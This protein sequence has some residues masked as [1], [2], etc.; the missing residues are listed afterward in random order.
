MNFSVEKIALEN[1]LSSLQAFLEK[2]DNAEITSHIFF[3]VRDSKLILKATDHETGLEI[4]HNE[5]NITNDGIATCNGKKI[6]DIVRILKDGEVNIYF[7]NDEIHIKQNRSKYK[8]PSFNAE[9]FPNFPSLI[10]LPKVDINS[11]KLMNGFKKV[12]PTI[13]TNNPKF[14]LNGALLDIR[15]SV[16]NIV[17]TD[18]RR[19]A[20]FKIDNDSEKL[21]SLIIPKKAISEIQKLFNSDIEIFYDETNFI[22]KSQNYYFFT[23]V[24][25]GNFPDYE[26][27]IPRELKHNFSLPKMAIID[28]IKQVNIIAPEIKISFE[29]GKMIFESISNENMEAKTELEVDIAIGAPFSVAINSRYII[30]FLSNIDTET[31]GI[32][33]NEPNT[34]FELTSENFLTIIM[35]IIL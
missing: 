25:N 1:M 32:G 11:T 9:E 3:D 16:I 15:N 24:I 7:E 18:T 26:R 14:E 13:A 21:L 28:A 5:V 35:P 23:K 6:L 8:L 30:D 27:I 10:G 31:F 20:V 12:N 29:N 17:S 34:P 19:L 22:I 4:E 2:K 33:F